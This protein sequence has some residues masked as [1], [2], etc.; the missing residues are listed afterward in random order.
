M[1]RT[2][3]R[4]ISVFI[5]MVIILSV[6]PITD[7]F[8]EVYNGIAGEKITWSFNTET[9]VLEIN[10]IGNMPSWDD[11]YSIPWF[12]FHSYIKTVVIQDGITSIGKMAFPS[13]TNL[14]SITMPIHTP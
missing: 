2:R 4:I 8:A 11:S 12:S 9:E 3:N 7:T 6:I 13:C 10:G 14:T 1:K 5:T